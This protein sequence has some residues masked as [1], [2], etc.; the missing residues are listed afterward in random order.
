MTQRLA[1]LTEAQKLVNADH[2]ASMIK[3]VRVKNAAAYRKSVNWM[4]QHGDA[5]VIDYVYDYDQ[6][7]GPRNEYGVFY[8][9]GTTL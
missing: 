5:D 4:R 8:T 3:G 6:P 1:G 2:I 9:S 7:A